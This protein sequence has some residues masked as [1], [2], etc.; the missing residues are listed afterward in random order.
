MF[1]VKWSAL[2]GLFLLLPSAFPEARCPG[3]VASVHA[4][5]LAQSLNI[6]GVSVNHKGPY[7]FLLDTGAQITSMDPAL[8]TEL[9]LKAHVAGEIL[10]VASQETVAMALVDDLQV[11]EQGIPRS[12]VAIQPLTQLQAADPSIRGVL[13]GDFLRHFDVLIDQAKGLLC[14]GK[15]GE[16]RSHVHGEELAFAM[17]HPERGAAS[18]EPLILPVRL[19]GMAGRPLFLLLDSGANAPFL[20]RVEELMRMQSVAVQANISAGQHAHPAF[21][22]L[23]PQDM[24]IGKLLV[25]QISFATPAGNGNDAPKI[26]ADGLLPTSQFRRVYI[27]YHNRFAVLESW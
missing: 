19:S 8:A 5:H 18:T 1:N 9:Q 23:P 2:A 7:A 27:D 13:G 21:V 12:L 3:N 26:D 17:P 20:W 24:Q 14:L 10:G 6:V 16:M 22:I 11:G 4:R 25:H 15:S